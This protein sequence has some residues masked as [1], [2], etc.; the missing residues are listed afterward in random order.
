[1]WEQVCV[2][3]DMTDAAGARTDGCAFRRGQVSHVHLL[4]ASAFSFLLVLLVLLLL[5]PPPPP[6]PPPPPLS[7]IPLVT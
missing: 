5:L 1:M 4:R 6:P 2:L 3:A 7:S